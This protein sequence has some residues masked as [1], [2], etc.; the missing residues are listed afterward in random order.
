MIDFL[1]DEKI[2]NR[3]EVNITS[4][5]Y[6]FLYPK[7]GESQFEEWT[8]DPFIVFQ[9][10]TGKSPFVEVLD[11]EP[12]NAFSEGLEVNNI[13]KTRK[14]QCWYSFQGGDILTSNEIVILGGQAFDVMM[15]RLKDLPTPVL[16]YEE[17]K[18][19]LA[20][21]L[22]KDASNLI[23]IGSKSKSNEEAIPKGNK[24]SYEILFKPESWFYSKNVK[25]AKISIGTDLPH[26]DLYITLTGEF[27]KESQPKPIILLAQIEDYNSRH[28]EIDELNEK[29]N[30]LEIEL[31]THFYVIRN[32]LPCIYIKNIWVFLFYNNC[33][34]EN[35]FKSKT[36]WLPCYLCPLKNG[37]QRERVRTFQNC[38]ELIWKALGFEVKFIEADFINVSSRRG[39]LHCLTKEINR[40][41]YSPF[42]Y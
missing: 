6:L 5:E 30:R 31:S 10:D 24:I 3:G 8:R 7:T 18:Q 9:D 21:I 14:S 1:A 25:K 38:N 4:S 33:L 23:I 29:L 41:N 11:Y 20:E 27:S 32:K 16:G 19:K 28:T 15:T 34:I 22:N 26:I 42:K 2:I 17:G 39:S 37:T 40:E 13:V 12:S 36:V 35:S